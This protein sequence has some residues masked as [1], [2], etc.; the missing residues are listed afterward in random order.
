VDDQFHVGIHENLIGP[1]AI[2]RGVALEKWLA[3]DI[4]LRLKSHALEAWEIVAAA[5]E[6]IDAV[7]ACA[8]RLILENSAAGILPNGGYRLAMAP[9]GI[10]A[11]DVFDGPS[12]VSL[13]PWATV[14]SA[15]LV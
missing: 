5:T 6:K 14:Y 1:S 7:P 10:Q 2:W 12:N 4:D 13:I 8:Y 3:N 15:M 9:D 11:N